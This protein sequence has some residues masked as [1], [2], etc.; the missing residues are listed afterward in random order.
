MLTAER[1]LDEKQN[2]R[3]HI[4]SNICLQGRAKEQEEM[5]VSTE[6]EL[7]SQAGTSEQRRHK[8]LE[9]KMQWWLKARLVLGEK[10]NRHIQKCKETLELR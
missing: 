8:I 5:E 9:V 7:P 3:W 4:E 2:I 10:K 6:T 1:R